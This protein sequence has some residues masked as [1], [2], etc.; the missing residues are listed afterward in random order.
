MQQIK[1]EIEEADVKIKSTEN[2]FTVTYEY[3]A[4]QIISR[5]EKIKNL[6]TNLGK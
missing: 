6:S 4:N 2:N 3:V 5:V 1:K